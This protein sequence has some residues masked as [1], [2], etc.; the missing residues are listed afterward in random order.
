MEPGLKLAPMAAAGGRREWPWAGNR[1]ATAVGS[2]PIAAGTGLVMSPGV[3]PATIMAR[4]PLTRPTAGYG[5]RALN[6]RQRGYI[7]VSGAVT[8]V[9]HL[10]HRTA[11]WRRGHT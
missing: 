2:G 1:I 7:G 3:G 6:G 11:W 5:C 8:A 10:A 9:G 4:G